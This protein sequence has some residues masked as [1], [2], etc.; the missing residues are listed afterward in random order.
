MG[1]TTV[2]TPPPDQMPYAMPPDQNGAIPQQPVPAYNPP[3]QQQQ[4]PDD[5]PIINMQPGAHIDPVL[6]AAAVHHA[7]LASIA[8]KLGDIMGGGSTTLRMIK[9]QDGSV[10]VAPEPATAGEKWG[11]V[12]AA[13]LSGAAQGFQHGQ[14]PGGPARAA[15]AGIQTGMGMPQARQDQ[16]LAT[17]EE[18]NNQ[19]RA[20]MLFKANMAKLNQDAVASAWTLKNNQIKAGEGEED[21]AQNIQQEMD[22]MGA[23]RYHVADMEDT[24]N[25]YNGDADL[26]QAHHDGRTLFFKT[27]DGKGNVNGGDIYVVPEDKL[28]QKTGEDWVRQHM[29]WDGN[30]DHEPVMNK[31][32]V[33]K[34]VMTEGQKMAAQQKDEADN[35]KLS[36]EYN[37]AT[38]IA[39]QAKATQAQAAA[40]RAEAAASRAG[41]DAATREANKKED[42]ADMPY[43]A[44]ALND[45]STGAKMT[46]FRS[47]S[48]GDILRYMTEHGQQLQQKLTGQELTRADSARIA[49]PYIEKAQAIVNQH[50]EIFGPA[51]WGRT[52]MSQLLKGGNP[53]AK[54]FQTQM[55]L[56]NL[57]MVSMHGFRGRYGV[58]DL[59]NLDSDLYTNPDAMRSVLSDL[60][61]G[62]T[63]ISKDGGRH[64]PSELQK[65]TTQQTNV[66]QAA[67]QPG[68]RV[69]PV[70]QGHTPQAN[71]VKGSDNKFYWIEPGNMAGAKQADPNL[72]V[73]PR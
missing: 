21:R 60:H 31:V 46:D 57:P 44:A 17:A 11:R 38:G 14:G 30:S 50:P 67:I 23:K 22:K 15:A 13:A 20:G 27:F 16:T 61:T 34:G 54:D 24:A 28:D 42:P 47:A 5:Q 12:A 29:T 43:I 18:A 33:P 52:K 35:S 49:L 66:S 19:N 56:A 65:P 64:V 73:I 2:T 69:P 58:Q 70:P 3:P 41:V 36:I 10:S 1:G 8:S 68:I 6:Q 37:K 25:A 45:P 71:Y 72:Q 55:T 62:A 32:P 7:R 40:T 9:N 63:S 59:A 51:G 53:V 39:A 26:Q 4:P 48:R